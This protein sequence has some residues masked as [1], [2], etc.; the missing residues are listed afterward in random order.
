M[1]VSALSLSRRPFDLN[2]V[3]STTISLM[4]LRIMTA[5]LDTRLLQH[6]KISNISTTTTEPHFLITLSH[7]P[8]S[9][10]STISILL[11]SN[12]ISYTRRWP[13]HRK[14]VARSAFMTSQSKLALLYSMLKAH[15]SIRRPAPIRHTLP[16]L[17]LQR[18]PIDQA[19]RQIGRA[20][21]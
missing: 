20:H 5:L 8:L 2:M 10:S 14:T 7:S 12:V 19:F 3:M 16:C 4:T 15:G 9:N 18:Q 11:F 13:V 1:E 17:R 21:V 6:I